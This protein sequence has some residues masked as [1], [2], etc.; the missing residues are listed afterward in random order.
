MKWSFVQVVVT[1]IVFAILAVHAVLFVNALK[2]EINDAKHKQEIVSSEN[3]TIENSAI[4]DNIHT[5]QINIQERIN[6]ARE[7]TVKEELISLSNKYNIY[8][9]NEYIGNI[10]GKFINITGDVFTFRDKNEN[11]ISSE[12]QIKRWGIRLNRLAEL[13]DKSNNII[14]L[15][16]RRCNK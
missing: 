11:V 10:S 8:I 16:R 14:R 9:D 12:K 3:N 5:E 7:I 4:E 1:L 6:S 13:R 2:S 15:Y